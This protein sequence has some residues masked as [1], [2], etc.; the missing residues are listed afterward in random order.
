MESI[1]E[2]YQIAPEP[3][4]KK[5]RV[6]YRSR[7]HF[8]SVPASFSPTITSTTSGISSIPVPCPSPSSSAPPCATSSAVP[9]SVHQMKTNT[10][11]RRRLWTRET[12]SQFNGDIRK[13][14]SCGAH[15][16]RSRTGSIPDKGIEKRDKKKQKICKRSGVAAHLREENPEIV[17]IH[18]LAHRLELAFKDAIKQIGNRLY[19]KTTTLLLGWFFYWLRRDSPQVVLALALSFAASSL[20]A[21]H[22]VLTFFDG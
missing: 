9:P 16:L 18:C 11:L 3:P 1:Q 12:P 20:A 4:T 15:I 21:P 19:E 17:I 10:A 6:G 13:W 7:F 22:D 8:P 14:M 5:N 2:Y